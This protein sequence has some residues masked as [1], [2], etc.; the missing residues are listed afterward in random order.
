MLRD[1]LEKTNLWGAVR[2][3]PA[4]NPLSEII[5]VG[6]VLESDGT[7][8]QVSISV[9]DT[10]GKNWY[11]RKYKGSAGKFS[12][13]TDLNIPGDPFQDMYNSI[14]NDLYLYRQKLDSEELAHIRTV[15]N[16]RYAADL[17][18]DAFGKHL[19]TDKKGL[20]TINRL[21]SESDPMM[22]RVERIRQSEFLFI[23]TV[24]QQYGRFFH[25]MDGTYDSWRRFSFEE[26]NAEREVKKSARRRMLA[27][28]ATL[29]GGVLVSS[30][31]NNSATNIIGQAAALG[32]LT[33]IKQ[34]WDVG[35]QAK[36]HEDALQE[37]AVS[38]D[39]E[40]APIVVEVDGEIVK[41][42]GTLD[43]Q[44]RNW[45]DLLRQIYADETAVPEEALAKEFTTSS[46]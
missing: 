11:T 7:V 37:L 45:R 26:V 13:R 23:D 17:S 35:K 27:G 40:I 28:A 16:L 25:E 42:E 29:I 38:F 18:P 4:E 41:L 9:S 43:D 1:T 2:M 15:A 20:W 12:Y 5:I 10:T 46:N 31:A 32:G 14:A 34:G 44:Y 36:I 6:E 3:V 21:P 33:A 30:N 19:K 39:A 22:A 24:D 8:L